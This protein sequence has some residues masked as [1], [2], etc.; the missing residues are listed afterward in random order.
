MMQEWEFYYMQYN[1][2]QFGESKEFLTRSPYFA[3]YRE[4]K[5]VP[6]PSDFYLMDDSGI[7]LVN[8]DEDYLVTP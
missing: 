4:A 8:D 5:P 1:N 2:E 7:E 6:P 3:D